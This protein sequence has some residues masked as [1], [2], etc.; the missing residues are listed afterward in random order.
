LSTPFVHPSHNIV[1]PSEFA[2][3][4]YLVRVHEDHYQACEP[5]EKKRKMEIIAHPKYGLSHPLILL[6]PERKKNRTRH[7][8]AD[9][10]KCKQDL[11]QIEFQGNTI[12]VGLPHEPQHCAN[13]QYA[14]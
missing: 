12:P 9:D 14:P 11:Y 7:L 10:I 5:I 4:R 6:P 8:I 2:H 1:L 3:V 13:S